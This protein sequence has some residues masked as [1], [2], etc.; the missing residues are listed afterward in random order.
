[1][2]ISEFARA[3]IDSQGQEIPAPDWEYLVA[4]QSVNIGVSSTQSNALNSTTRFVLLSMDAAC[5]LAYG[6]NPTAVTTA[7][8]C[9]TNEVR[10]Y[11][12]GGGKKLAVIANT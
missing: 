6:A 2:Y 12:A 4:E 5:S 3:A 9:A 7:H 11:G 10:F 1:L 8:R